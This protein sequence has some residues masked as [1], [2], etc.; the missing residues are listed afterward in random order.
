LKPSI[1]SGTNFIVLREN[2]GGAYYGTKHE[3]ENH[4][5][6]T[7]EY[8]R[9]EIERCARVAAALAEK[10][11]KDGRDTG[12]GSPATV[13]SADKANVLASGRL[14]RKVTSEVFEKEF[15]RKSPAQAGSPRPGAH[16]SINNS[17]VIH[18][19]V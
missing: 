1:A 19:K 17:A 14:W 11:G 15:P 10:M 3:D 18:S 16:P 4:A 9:P 5:Y 12:T 6:D 2:C 7:W 13:W 8:T